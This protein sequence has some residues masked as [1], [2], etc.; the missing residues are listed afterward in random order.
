MQ[1]EGLT[2]SVVRDAIEHGTPTQGPSGR[3]GYYSSENN[4]TVVTEEGRVV[5]VTSGRLRIR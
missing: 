5:T 4:L 3:V 2:P 1:S